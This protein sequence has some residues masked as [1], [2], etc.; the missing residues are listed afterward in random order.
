M[1]GL[2]VVAL[3][4]GVS[5]DVLA[6]GAVELRAEP[7]SVSGVPG[8]PLR[9]VLTVVTERATPLHLR[10]PAVSN[11]VLRTVERVP[12]RLTEEGQYVQRRT[13]LWQGVEAGSTTITN[14]LAEMSGATNVFPAVDIAIEAVEPAM[15]PPPP[16][17]EEETPE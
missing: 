17:E 15:P 16:V 3:A 5:L 2:V 7:R 8:A 11:L 12:I 4:C 6:G 13:I 9:V 14:L 10:I 1:W